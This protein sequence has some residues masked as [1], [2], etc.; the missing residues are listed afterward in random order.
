VTLDKT[1]HCLDPNNAACKSRRLEQQ[2]HED[3]RLSG[4]KK[5]KTDFDT[6][7]ECLTKSCELDLA[8]KCAQIPDIFTL[9]GHTG[10]AMMIFESGMHFDFAQAQTV[11]PWAC[12]VAVLGTFLPLVAGAALSVAFGYKLYPDGLAAGVSL[13]PTSIGIALKLLHEAQALQTY[14]GQAVMTAAFVDDVLALILFSVLFSLGDDMNFLTFLPLILGCLFMLVAVIAAVKVWP[15]FIM[16]MFSKIPETKPDAKV[17]RHDEVMWLLMFVTLCAYAQITHLCGTHLWGCFIAGMCFSTQHYAVHVWVKQVKR[18]TVWWLRLFF[19]CTLAWSIPI[20]D[21]FT[22][23]AFW[24]GSIMGIGPCV[25]MKVFCAPFMGS[26]RWVIGWAMVG[27]AEFAYFI[28]IMAKSLKMMPDKLFAILI[29]ALIYATI[30][31]PLIF[32]NV[33]A[34]YM[35]VQAALESGSEPPSPK[36]A[37]TSGDARRASKGLPDLHELNRAEA[38]Q[39]AARANANR[40]NELEARVGTKSQNLR[41]AGAESVQDDMNIESMDLN[42]PLPAKSLPG[43]IP[44]VEVAVCK[45]TVVKDEKQQ[46]MSTGEVEALLAKLR[47]EEEQRTFGDD[48]LPLIADGVRLGEEV[49][50]ARQAS[51]DSQRKAADLEERLRV[52]SEQC[53]KLRESAVQ[54]EEEAGV[55]RQTSQRSQARLEAEAAGL[56]SELVAAELSAEVKQ[57]ASLQQRPEAED[58]SAKMSKSQT[59]G[60]NVLC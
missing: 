35:A 13:S 2:S 1:V 7:H 47:R 25:L 17:T 16:W 54:S 51:A 3:R 59:D 58:S 55:F 28:A 23:E 10:V 52:M 18:F 34:R 12:A 39:K 32:R 29:W 37:F 9:V 50:A 57:E 26:A 11:G 14:F 48:A 33:L 15:Q 44:N 45:E 42:S 20:N 30:F 8:I 22:L 56:R 36:F 43:K 6:Y 41:A 4:D 5:G 31:A 46:E 27:R 40:I 21:L 60:S 38:A 53:N 49:T 24:Q 19:A